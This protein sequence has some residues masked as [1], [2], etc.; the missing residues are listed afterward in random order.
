MG[1]ILHSFATTKEAVR[2]AIQNSQE[3]L[4]DLAKS[5]PLNP[6]IVAKWQKRNY[7]HDTVMGPKEIHSTVLTAEEEA[8]I[9]AFR[10]T[11]LLPLDD[12]L[13]YPIVWITKS[14][15]KE[16][17]L[18]L[19]GLNISIVLELVP[20]VSNSTNLTINSLDNS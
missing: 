17:I 15:Y 20:Y 8:V 13:Y 4:N 6:K 14:D 16:E 19:S 7:I 12:C 18:Y 2:R 5:Y 11:T 1:Q 3:S 9:V 10:K